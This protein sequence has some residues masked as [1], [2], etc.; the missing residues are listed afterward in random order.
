[1]SLL[2]YSVLSD[3]LKQLHYF[4]LRVRILKEEGDHGRGERGEPGNEADKV[5]GDAG[6]VR[7]GPAGDQSHQKEAFYR[8]QHSNQES[9]R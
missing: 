1:M 9:L 3:C 2:F 4:L 7:P 8:R 6:R 5:A